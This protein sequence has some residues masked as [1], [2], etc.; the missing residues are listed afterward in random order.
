MSL[1][2]EGS[3]YSTV[4]TASSYIHNQVRIVQSFATATLSRV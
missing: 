3:F 1:N 2:Y 4:S